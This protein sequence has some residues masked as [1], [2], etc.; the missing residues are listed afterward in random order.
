[1][2]R[3]SPLTEFALLASAPDEALNLEQLSLGVARLAHPELDGKA[4]SRKLDA[5]ADH[6]QDRLTTSTS[7]D[8][9]A[10]SLRALI[11]GDLGFRGSQE[12]YQSIQGSCLD[13]VLES[14]SG[15]PILLSVVWILLGERLGI[16]IKGVGYPGHFLVCIDVSSA[17]IYLDPYA[18]GEE[19]P[20][21]ELLL[22]QTDRSV[23]NPTGTRAIVVRMLTNIKH[24]AIDQQ[25][26]ELG[27]A[28]VDRIQLLT[29]NE[30]LNFRALSIRD[31]GLF[32]MHLSRNID[33]RKELQ[34]YLK[35]V[36][37]ALDRTEVEQL[38][39]ALGEEAG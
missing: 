7:P 6:I 15:L 35:L 8:R 32:L 37:D 2:P 29:G 17:R 20:S 1:M 28:V 36:P 34:Q 33:A 38:L 14:R 11:G 23:L 16:P 26:W 31:R 24:L 30:A 9:V 22:N 13:Q 27:L 25:N 3:L 4:I 5:L 39:L 21:Q 18:G 10:A 12:A 19:R